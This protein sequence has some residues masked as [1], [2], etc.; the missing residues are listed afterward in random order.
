MLQSQH[1]PFWN[2]VKIYKFDST[3]FYF[4]LPNL[5]YQRWP[6]FNFPQLVLVFW[7]KHAQH[8][9]GQISVPMVHWK[10]GLN[11]PF[12]R[13]VIQREIW[14]VHWADGVTQNRASIEPAEKFLWPKLPRM[15]FILFYSP[16][17]I[18]N[19]IISILFVHMFCF[20]VKKVYSCFNFRN[21][22]FLRSL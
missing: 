15:T 10:E 17:F 9:L 22:Q 5:A 21:L 8:P 4:S 11:L 6:E 18:F 14:A 3:G 12:S 20:M 19:N 2:S 16:Y 13:P 7:V 1:W